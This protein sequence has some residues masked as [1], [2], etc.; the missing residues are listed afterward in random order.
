[1]TMTALAEPATWDVRTSLTIRG[2][3]C[4]PDTLSA[5]LDLVPHHV[6]RRGGTLW[7]VWSRPDAAAGNEWVWRPEPELPADLPDARPARIG[8]GDL[9][10]PLCRALAERRDRLA[11][12]PA[13][14][15]EIRI[16]IVPQGALPEI[17]FTAGDLAALRDLGLDWSVDLRTVTH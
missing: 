12:L 17:D 3:D 14:R 6:V 4:D 16:E 2:F 9:L 15:G 13:C 8:L 11:T 7:Q 1:M 10:R 5:H